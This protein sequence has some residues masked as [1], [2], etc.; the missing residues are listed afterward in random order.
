VRIYSY[1]GP[2]WCA[3]LVTFLIYA[4]VGFEIFRKRSALKAFSSG[5]ATHNT[6]V[7]Q[8]AAGTMENSNS[9]VGGQSR[10]NSSTSISNQS[11]KT[12]PFTGT[13]TTE[14]EVTST[15]STLMSPAPSHNPPERVQ[16]PGNFVDITTA[17]EKKPRRKYH[18]ITRSWYSTFKRRLNRIDH[19]KLA[20]TRCAILFAISILVTWVPSSANRVYT[21]CHT[22]PSYALSFAA[23][24]VLPLQ[25]FWNT[26]IFFWTSWGII[27][28]EYRQW[29]MA[30]AAA[31]HRRQSANTASTINMAERNSQIPPYVDSMDGYDENETESTRQVLDEDDLPD[32]DIRPS[33]QTFSSHGYT[34]KSVGERDSYMR[35][36]TGER[37]TSSA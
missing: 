24:A 10:R 37:P 11:V 25:G 22:D 5:N 6:L 8:S 26:T 34:R 14:V 23:A 1:Y 21:L 4:R 32:F 17:S 20:Y 12:K 19:V 29:R 18:D 31:A 33:G 3:I 27:K 13:R 28:T 9:W 2:V 7:S 35:N 15:R 16:E 30:K 36:S